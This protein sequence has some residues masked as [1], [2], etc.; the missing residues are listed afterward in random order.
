MQSRVDQL[1]ANVS[2]LG[3]A[4]RARDFMMSIGIMQ[5]NDATITSP[6]QTEKGKAKNLEEAVSD[7]LPTQHIGFTYL[8]APLYILTE[9]STACHQKASTREKGQR[10]TLA[11][12]QK[13]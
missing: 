13:V 1:E 7:I 2:E 9:K 11:I 3:S 10:E 12:A 6:N 5:T 4:D 8:V